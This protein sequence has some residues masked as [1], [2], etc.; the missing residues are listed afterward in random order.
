MARRAKIKT[1]TYTPRLPAIRKGFKPGLAIA[2]ARKSPP[3]AL[4]YFPTPPWAT[5][6]LVELVLPE[7]GLDLDGAFVWEPACGEGHMALVL[8]E[9][10]ARVFASDV[11]DYDLVLPGSRGCGAAQ[12]VGSFIGE[13]LD[14]IESPAGK[15]GRIDWIITNP[16]FAKA[17][18]F[19]LRALNEA[20]FTALLLRSNWAET[21]ERYEAIFRD[22]PPLAIA[23]FAER[24]PMTKGEW[25]PQSATATAYAWFVWRR[26]SRAHTRFLWIPPGQRRVLERSTDRARF[27]KQADAP[28]LMA[29][30]VEKPRGGVRK[31][32]VAGRG[33][34]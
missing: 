34:S 32:E 3:D 20:R 12:G 29:M 11:H 28:L 24:V 30:G 19:A 21:Q 13:G 31:S 9:Y 10:A 25:R 6:A 23:Q 8:A 16:P 7:L 17:D 33:R 1:A 27:T 15:G 5:R 26:G 14:V 2:N 22:R 4:D 18:E